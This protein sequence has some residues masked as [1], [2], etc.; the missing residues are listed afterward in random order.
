MIPIGTHGLQCLDDDDPA[1]VALYIQA[2]ALAIDTLLDGISDSFD[3]T[4]LR[5]GFTGATTIVNGPIASGGEA[6]FGLNGWAL[7]SSNFLPAPT[8]TLGFQFTVPRTGWWESGLYLNAQASGA[9]TV[10]SRRTAYN[11][12]YRVAATGNVLIGEGVWRTYDT[13]T[14]GEF[15][16]VSGTSFYAAAGTAVRVLPQWSHTNAASTVQVNAGAKLWCFYIGS[17]VEIGSA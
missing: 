11:R 4:Y 9:V 2:E 13:N 5:P 16:V 3:A 6:Q 10:N 17:G 8:A 15:L 1:A 7:T 14:G 12:V